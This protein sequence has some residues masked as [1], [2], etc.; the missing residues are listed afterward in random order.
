[1]LMV[2]TTLL[3]VSIVLPSVATAE[4]QDSQGSRSDMARLSRS[5]N[6]DVYFNSNAVATSVLLKAN[7]DQRPLLRTNLKRSIRLVDSQLERAEFLKQGISLAQINELFKS[8]G[9]GRIESFNDLYVIKNF[10]NGIDGF[11]EDAIY[12]RSMKE[13]DQTNFWYAVIPRD[14]VVEQI[15]A[16]REW[17]VEGVGTH[18]QLR[19]KLDSPI[20]LIPQDK[21]VNSRIGIVDMTKSNWKKRFSVDQNTAHLIPGDMVYSMMALRYTGGPADWS[22]LTGI[23][24][25]FANAYTL[26]SIAHNVTYLA[27]ENFVEQHALINPKTLGTITLKSVFAR[28]NKFGERNIYHLI[29]NSCITEMNAALYAEGKAYPIQ[30][31]G[32]QPSNFNSYSFIESLAPLYQNK[33]IKSLNSEFDSP[34]LQ[35]FVSPNLEKSMDYIQQPAFDTFVQEITYK[36]SPLTYND[37]LKFQAV[38]EESL[39]A[40]AKN[41]LTLSQNASSEKF[42]STIKNLGVVFPEQIG[43]LNSKQYADVI[44]Q[45]LQNDKAVQILKLYV[46]KL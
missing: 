39:A 17:F 4:F 27:G 15:L 16:Q 5:Q 32:A 3:L 14:V 20:L 30:Q 11:K 31:I 45:L 42:M 19:F 43:E 2:L 21:A 38:Y 12:K 41:S 18:G 6:V 22:F 37:L 10:A 23:G 28:A 26:S 34:V 1:M 7:N 44:I 9:H 46:Q 36:L 13:T 40:L 24:G 25:A 8:Y 33:E 35:K 29:F